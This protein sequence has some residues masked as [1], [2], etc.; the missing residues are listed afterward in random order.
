MVKIAQ[1]KDREDLVGRIESESLLEVIDHIVKRKS[2][3]YLW[4]RFGGEEGNFYFRE[5]KL[6]YAGSRSLRGKEAAY[7]P[8]AFRTGIFRIVRGREPETENVDID[9]QTFKKNFLAELQKLVLNF[10]PDLEG[11][12]IIKI[13]DF[14]L[15]D[16]FYHFESGSRLQREI[17][18]QLFQAGAE[19]GFKSLVRGLED[20]V[21]E[22]REGF[23]SAVYYIPELRYFIGVSG[24]K[25]EQEQIDGWMLQ[26]FI[27][28]AR[29]SVS[30]ALR[31]SDRLS[32]R[33]GVLAVIPDRLLGE[34]A[35]SALSSAGFKSWICRDGFEGLVRAEDYRPDLIVLSY[36]L[37]RISSAEVYARLKRKEESQMIPV[38]CLVPELH[39]PELEKA[40]CGDIYYE[41]PFSGK[42]LVKMVENLLEL[43]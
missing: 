8:L 19:H 32:V 22:F 11:K 40:A 7:H 21:I 26:Q 12:F 6:V 5:G 9:W 37:D 18:I 15:R 33:A 36:D 10:L 43:K 4:I 31:R 30:V 23:F 14:K 20:K 16:L 28:R 3:M 1:F 24:E 41:L 35:R 2:P 29:E 38:I 39:R 17:L 25:Q 42:K 13:V 34:Q 27:P